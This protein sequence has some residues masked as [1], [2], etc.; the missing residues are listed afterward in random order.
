MRSLLSA[1]IATLI[2]GAAAPHGQPRQATRTKAL[3]GGTLVDVIS[4]LIADRRS[5]P[6]PA[7]G[8]DRR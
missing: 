1:L 4:T 6:T 3:V 5:G 2:L 8:G 7:I